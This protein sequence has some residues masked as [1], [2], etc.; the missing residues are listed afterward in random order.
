VKKIKLNPVSAIIYLLFVFSNASFLFAE[1]NINVLS[2]SEKITALE[3]RSDIPDDTFLLDNFTENLYYVINGQKKYFNSL[4][5]KQVRESNRWIGIWKTKP[6]GYITIS[7]NSTD[8]GY[9]LSLTCS[10]N[11]NIH[12]WGMNLTANFDEYFTGIFERTVDGDQKN[13]REPG[14]TEAMD[15]K[16]L[17]KTVFSSK[18]N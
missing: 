16:K 2:N 13:S 8:S 5:D 12:G 17:E 1:N 11:L 4:P 6:Q 3:F 14:I 7:V 10:D 18:S 15:L 9:T